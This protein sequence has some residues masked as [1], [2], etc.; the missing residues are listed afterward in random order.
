[1][2]RYSILEKNPKI[3]EKVFGIPFD[4]LKFLF[5]KVK[6]LH[7]NELENNPISKRG[8]KPKFTLEN[9]FL[10][11]IEYL[12]NYPTFEVLGFSYGISD[13]YAVKCFHKILPLL[14]EAIGLKNP[15]KISFKKVRKAIIDVSCQP[16]ER[17]T[18]DQQESYNAYKKTISQ[19]HN[20]L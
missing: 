9:Q 4:T 15:D 5:E 1:M 10:L 11:T 2:D 17:P 14:S 19:K 13:S 3:S 18:K 6:I 16:I 8:L 20:L 12:K 7:L